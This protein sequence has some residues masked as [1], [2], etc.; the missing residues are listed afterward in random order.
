MYR[1][2]EMIKE[3]YCIN[4][5]IMD[6]AC[7]PWGPSYWKVIHMFA[8]HGLGRE[9]LKKMNQYL[10][11]RE[12]EEQWVDPGLDDLVEWS[13]NLH[14]QVNASLNKYSGWT[15]DDFYISYTKRG[16]DHCKGDGHWPWDFLL[17]VGHLDREGTVEWLKEFQE[18][19]PCLGCR[20]QFFLDDPMPDEKVFDWVL[21]HHI[22]FHSFLE[23]GEHVQTVTLQET[24]PLP[25]PQLDST[26]EE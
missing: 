14:N 20:S 23:K 5:N 7:I 21:R 17:V 16:C 4:V 2:K 15:L 6:N 22:R 10:P 11:T 12:A 1:D 8:I 24:P 25:P 3:I 19:Y 26:V 9:W 18:L 13:I